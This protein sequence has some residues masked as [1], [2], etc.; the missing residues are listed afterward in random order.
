MSKIRLPLRAL[1]VLVCWRLAGFASVQIGAS[2][3]YFY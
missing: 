2:D 1:L 3:D